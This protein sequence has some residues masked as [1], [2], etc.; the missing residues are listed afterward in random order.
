MKEFSDKVNDYVS[1]R[2]LPYNNIDELNRK[3]IYAGI[4]DAINKTGYNPSVIDL[5]SINNK[6]RKRYRLI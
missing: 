3:M 2:I 4:K 5:I 1:K 6:I